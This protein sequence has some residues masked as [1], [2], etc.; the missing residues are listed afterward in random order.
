LLDSPSTSAEQCLGPRKTAIGGNK[1]C[2]L[3]YLVPDAV[4][5]GADTLVSIRV[6]SNHSRQVATVAA[7]LG[8]KCRLV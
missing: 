2:K 3:E 5:K 7:K 6:Q 4:A 1:V 8:L